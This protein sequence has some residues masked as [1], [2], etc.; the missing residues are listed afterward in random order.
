VRVETDRIEEKMSSK[1]KRGGEGGGGVALTVVLPGEEIEL[2]SEGSIV[3]GP[4][5]RRIGGEKVRFDEQN[6]ESLLLARFS[7]PTLSPSLPLSH[8][9]L[10]ALVIL[11]SELTVRLNGVAGCCK[12]VW[13]TPDTWQWGLLG[14]HVHSSCRGS[15]WG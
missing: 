12:Q 9:S 4:G 7:S 11:L 3:L 5:I 10:L 13:G 8:T 2:P 14:R 15:H 6:Q 1:R